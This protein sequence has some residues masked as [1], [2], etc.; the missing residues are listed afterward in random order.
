MCEK[1]DIIYWTQF[2]KEPKRAV[3]VWNS[4]VSTALLNEVEWLV[5][6]CYTGTSSMC[7]STSPNV[8]AFERIRSTLALLRF[9][10][11]FL[12]MCGRVYDHMISCILCPHC[13]K[14]QIQNVA[15]ECCIIVLVAELVLFMWSLKRLSPA[16]F[17]LLC[18]ADVLLGTSA[19][20]QKC[21]FIKNRQTVRRG[22]GPVVQ[23]AL[24]GQ[25]T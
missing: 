3:H 16:F 15:S 18:V 5:A 21:V 25:K 12:H 14:L 10:S 9:H 11:E 6:S 22:H 20:W 4:A 24:L 19:S 2:G 23:S 7:T 17:F 13:A 1:P 8:T